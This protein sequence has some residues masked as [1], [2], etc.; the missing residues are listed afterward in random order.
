M[1][2]FSHY[3]MP[4]RS[5]RTRKS[6]VVPS[7]CLEKSVSFSRTF[8]QNKFEPAAGQ[9]S[10]DSISLGSDWDTTVKTLVTRLI[11]KNKQSLLS[12]E[13]GDFP[14]DT[15]PQPSSNTFP[16]TETV[17][18]HKPVTPDSRSSPSAKEIIQSQHKSHNKSTH[19]STHDVT[20]QNVMASRTTRSEKRRQ[21]SAATDRNSQLSP[22]PSGKERMEESRSPYKSVRSS[23]RHMSTTPGIKK[24]KHNPAKKTC[25][26]GS[27]AV[28][29][30]RGAVSRKRSSKTSSHETSCRG[31]MSLRHRSPNSQPKESTRRP[32]K[33]VH[34]E[35]FPFEESRSDAESPKAPLEERI[36]R[37]H[38]KSKKPLQR[39]LEDPQ[40]ERQ[41]QS[42]KKRTDKEN[43]KSVSPKR[44][45]FVQVS[46]GRT[47]TTDTKSSPE[48]PYDA[49]AST[50]AEQ[51]SGSSWIERARLGRIK[52]KLV[53]D[54]SAGAPELQSIVHSERE[55]RLQRLSDITGG[56]YDS[57]ATRGGASA[58]A[59]RP[60]S[61]I[62]AGSSQE[63]SQT[64]FMQPNTTRA[65]MVQVDMAAK[66]T[67]PNHNGTPFRGSARSA[68][69]SMMAESNT[70]SS[71]GGSRAAVFKGSPSKS[72]IPKAIRRRRDTVDYLADEQMHRF[73][74]TS[75]PCDTMDAV[76]HYSDAFFDFL[77]KKLEESALRRGSR[78]VTEKDVI[79]FIRNFKGMRSTH[80]LFA[81]V[82]EHMSGDLRTQ[83]VPCSRQK[84]RRK[85]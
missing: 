84:K 22:E 7:G 46:V 14:G 59:L 74:G 12:A 35:E 81:M 83:M 85:K 60:I 38:S 1:R 21:N 27:S 25:E 44:K 53:L 33:Q 24:T 48:R 77:C 73:L 8:H 6:G 18:V 37:S 29:D 26:E 70:Q 10:S 11:T 66:H 13:H 41:G 36:L 4:R 31:R 57:V 71:E 47:P 49:H 64:E 80:H 34:N 19:K 67:P 32:A 72:H 17:G 63:N 69:G 2:G 61:D 20:P 40:T 42:P 75:V 62:D 51:R 54:V 43:Q 45:L 39:K 23:T 52:R 78:K 82:E 65:K 16:V 50:D 76:Y 56:R 9:A 3:E 58:I 28:E 55:P 15:S 5:L 79:L 68:A 30:I